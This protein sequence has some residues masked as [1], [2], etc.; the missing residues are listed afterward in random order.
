MLLAPTR[1]GGASKL[2]S[3]SNDCKTGRVA[4]T[5]GRDDVKM[6]LLSIVGRAQGIIVTAR[7]IEDGA[8]DIGLVRCGQADHRR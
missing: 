6:A 7:A 5:A 1:T 2:S 4:T 8:G 3:P